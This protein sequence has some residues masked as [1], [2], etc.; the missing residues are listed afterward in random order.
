MSIRSRLDVIGAVA[1]ALSDR[2]ARRS[3]LRAITAYDHIPPAECPCCG[4]LGRF[5]PAGKNARI[6]QLCPAC[7]SYERHRLVAVAFQ[8]RFLD[9]CGKDVLHFAPEPAIRP[10][11]L[12]EK[13][14]SYVTADIDPGLA[15][16]V[17]DLENVD[18][19]GA[20]FDV[21]IASHV[22]EHVDD[23]KALA[24]LHRILRPGGQLIAMVPI[25]EGWA[26]TYEDAA[27]TSPRDRASYFGRHDH[28]RYYG[29]DFRGRVKN[30]GFDLA[31]F[32]AGPI[33]SVRYR[34][35]RGEKVF[36]A[37]KRGD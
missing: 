11:V 22:L 24:E 26:E 21:V 15:D 34:L 20:S 9:L 17:L 27:K 3:L 2:Q 35:A 8:R 25:V 1:G 33:D 32:T 6:G 31:E 30:A 5:G 18:L 16:R 13:P 14:A 4:Y 28:V 29:A 10:L 36:L 37:T 12:N 19:P 7:R 23:A